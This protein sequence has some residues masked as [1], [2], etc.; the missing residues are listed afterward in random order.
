MVDELKRRLA[1]LRGVA[2]RLNTVADEM[3]RLVEQVE[4]TLV[5]EG[6]NVSATT[7]HWFSSE[8]HREEQ[9]EECLAFGR[10]R[11]A[12]GI[13]VLRRTFRERDNLGIFTHL[14][15]SVRIPWSECDRETRFQAFK[16][17]P[18]LLDRIMSQAEELVKNA[19][20]AT[21]KVREMISGDES[22]AP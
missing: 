9:V 4:K 2:P 19:D 11:G 22:A 20:E 3:N 10:V 18:Q 16:L 13:H 15:D 21:A 8:R 7:A 17:L 6:I 12:Y 5:D 1:A 14:V